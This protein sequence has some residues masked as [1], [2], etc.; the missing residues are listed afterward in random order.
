MGIPP[1]DLFMIAQLKSGILAYDEIT[2]SI[3]VDWVI[4]VSIMQGILGTLPSIRLSIKL[5][6][7]FGVRSKE[8]SV[9]AM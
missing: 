7:L 6:T 3:W 2:N 1:L 8:E 4:V 5:L 9:Y